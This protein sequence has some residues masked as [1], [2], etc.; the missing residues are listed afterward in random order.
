MLA[1]RYPDVPSGPAQGLDARGTHLAE[2]MAD[3]VP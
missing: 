1:S 3:G 2:N